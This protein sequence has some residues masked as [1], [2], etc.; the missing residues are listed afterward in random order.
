MVATSSKSAD[1]AVPNERTF[2]SSDEGLTF[3][4]CWASSIAYTDSATVEELAASAQL[5]M[6]HEDSEI[7][8]IDKPAYLPC[9]NT[10]NLKDS[11]RT[12]LELHVAIKA[13]ACEIEVDISSGTAPRSLY[14]PHRLDWETSGVMVVAK[15]KAA[16][17]SLSRQFAGRDVSKMCA[18]SERKA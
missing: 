5:T 9:E 7:L 16:M 10:L 13:G 14:L 8:V 15:T 1:T 12:R 11:V 4:V 17:S 3:S 18:A 2:V 6:L